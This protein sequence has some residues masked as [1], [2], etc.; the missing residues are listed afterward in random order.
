MRKNTE[1]NFWN[2]VAVGNPN[3]CWEWKS[4]SG[5]REYAETKWHG[6]YTSCHRKA[7]ELFTKSTIADGYE[8][9]HTCDNPPCCNPHHLFAGTRQDNVDD[10]ERKGRNQLPHSRGEEHGTHK[11]TEEEV[12]EIVYLYYKVG[13]HSYYSLAGL[14]GVSFGN[15]RKIVLGETW[16]W[17]TGLSHE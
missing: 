7:Y 8:I 4:K 10:R 14:F 12:L 5:T 16:G 2:N 6:K 1:D 13:G 15:I 17:L 3:E 9:C 11:L